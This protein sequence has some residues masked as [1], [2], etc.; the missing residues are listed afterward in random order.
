MIGG[1]PLGGS[2]VGSGGVPTAIIPPVAVNLSSPTAKATGATTATGTVVTDTGNGTLYWIA[3]TA[4]KETVSSVK[5]GSSKPVDFAGAQNVTSAGLTPGLTYRIHY[6][7]TTTVPEDAV[8]VSSAPFVAGVVGNPVRYIRDFLNGASGNAASYWVEIAAYNLAGTNVALGKTTTSGSTPSEFTL[9]RVTDGDIVSANYVAIS[10]ANANVTVD[11]GSV[12]DIVSVTRWH[13]YSDGRTFFSS[14]TQ[15][16]VDGV[17]WTDI[18]D[19]AVSGTYAETAGGKNDLTLPPAPVNVDQVGTLIPAYTASA[20]DWA[21]Y[22]ASVASTP[23]WAVFNPA[24]GPGVAFDSAYGGF[25]SAMRSAGGKALGYVSTS[26]AGTVV[27]SR[28]VAAVKADIDAYLSWYT[29]DGFFLDE[30]SVDTAP[31]TL[32]YYA[33]VYAYIKSKN[34]RYLVV[35]NPGINLPEVYAATPLADNFVMFE[36]TAATFASYAMPGW[37]AKYN[38][39]RFSWLVYAASSAEMST[40]ATRAKNAGVGF[41]FATGDTLPN[42]WDTVPTYWSAE[43]A[44]LE[45]P[46]PLDAQGSANPSGTASLSSA[47]PPAA[48]ASNSAA[49]PSAT[50]A[51][52]TAILLAGQGAARPIGSGLVTLGSA[53]VVS[54]NKASPSGT[55]SVSTV[56]G[57]ASIAS[58][59]PQATASLGTQLQTVAVGRAAPSANVALTTS[60]A[61][62]GTG[63]ASTAGAGSLVTAIPISSTGTAAP[64]GSGAIAVPSALSSS[65]SAS[66]SGVGTLT[67]AIRVSAAASASPGSSATLVS[68]G[69]ANV[70]A[71]GSS[72]PAGTSSLV[73]TI[74]LGATGLASPSGN[75]SLA[76]TIALQAVGA[77]KPEGLANISTTGTALLSTGTATPQGASNLTTVLSVVSAGIAKPVGSSALTPFAKD[78]SAAGVASPTGAALV[79]TGITISSSSAAKPS[80]S[81]AVGTAIEIAAGTSARPQGS[82]T[83][84]TSIPLVSA[85]VATPTGEA[86]LGKTPATISAVS[87]AAPV[88]T[89]QISTSITLAASATATPQGSS[90]LVPAASAALAATGSARPT[91]VTNVTTSIVLIAAS[92]ASPSG[93]ATLEQPGSSIAAAG[94]AKPSGVSQL[95][96]TVTVSAHGAAAPTAAAT[97]DTGVSLVAGSSA[98][99]F[100]VGTLTSIISVSAQGSANTD[101]RASEISTIISGVASGHAAPAG[102]AALENVVAS[103]A[104]LAANGSADPAAQAF[105]DT[106]ISVQASA[107]ADPGGSASIIDASDWYVSGFARPFGSGDISGLPAVNQFLAP[108]QVTATQVSVEYNVPTPLPPITVV[109]P[110]IHTL[111]IALQQKELA[112]TFFGPP[113]MTPKD[114]GG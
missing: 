77:A 9:A 10:D 61:I 34:P 110:E 82:G 114:R 111:L 59:K 47:V 81:A 72:N 27:T 80:G 35:G 4:A 22:T 94:L 40:A 38:P 93:S 65:A 7:Q 30:M 70:A 86:S 63:R 29:V 52:T 98:G 97:V 46:D 51:L 25:T 32:A 49:A 71:S 74:D 16:S 73:T 105:I 96:T 95:A 12:Q 60:L 2:P 14:R 67:T 76:T 53:A 20:G 56:I 107:G 100:G 23:T 87:S 24:S 103:G 45:G 41:L 19:S 42:P 113:F 64:F 6:T 91:S 54:S 31:A 26:W 78:L 44:A 99:A 69:A 106:L 37:A 5:A 3:T 36:G 28:T 88:G 109:T 92:K 50:A 112:E 8:V 55:S 66:P 15:T 39:K 13:F 104:S 33:E 21:T 101:A 43:V 75:C 108:T 48:I 18:F 84:T 89:S 57:I 83:I 68:A 85:G 17:I 11:L 90:E 58:A 62:Q 1:F 102:S 79:A